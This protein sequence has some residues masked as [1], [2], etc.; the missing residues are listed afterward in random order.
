[1]WLAAGLLASLVLCCHGAAENEPWGLRLLT[2]LRDK[3]SN[4][5]G[6]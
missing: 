2:N 3:D 6:D 5:D 1:M 4:K